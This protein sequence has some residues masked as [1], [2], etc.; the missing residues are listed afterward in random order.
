[1]SAD[2]RTHPTH[3]TTEP[4]S[5]DRPEPKRAT[6]NVPPLVWVIAAIL[7]LCAALAIMQYAGS[8]RTPQGGEV[9]R[10]EQP[11]AV[12]PAAPATPTA[13]G[14]PASSN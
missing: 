11:A 9:P 12:M 10:A 8:D 3:P 5:Y 7:V 13:P 1:M 14:T 2:N 6:R 4:D